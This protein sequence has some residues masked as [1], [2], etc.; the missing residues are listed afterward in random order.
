[1]SLKHFAEALLMTTH[2]CLEGPEV[3][4]DITAKLL[5]SYLVLYR[6]KASESLTQSWLSMR[7]PL[8]SS[9]TSEAPTER[10]RSFASFQDC[11]SL[12]CHCK[13]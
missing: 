1:M 5:H 6:Q 11:M 12:S 10:E 7:F 13:A 8:S 9:E 4:A 3:L 2:D